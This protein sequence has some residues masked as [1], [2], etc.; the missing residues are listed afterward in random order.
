LFAAALEGDAAAALGLASKGAAG[1]SS[2]SGA[3]L[4]EKEFERGRSSPAAAAAEGEGGAGASEV[5]DVLARG[6]GDAVEAAW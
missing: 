4:V 5:V 2:A 1:N 3:R 6:R